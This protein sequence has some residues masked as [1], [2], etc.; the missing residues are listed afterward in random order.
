M[1]E[2][3][4]TARPEISGHFLRSSVSPA[5]LRWRPQAFKFAFAARL[6][7]RALQ[8]SAFDQDCV[9]TGPRLKP[10]VAC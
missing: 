7:R 4:G 2:G 8:F 6:V 1:V 5:G 10:Y 3:A 9:V